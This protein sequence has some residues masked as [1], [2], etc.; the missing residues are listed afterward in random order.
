[1]AGFHGVMMYLCHETISSVFQDIQQSI[2]HAVMTDGCLSLL[3]E[4]IL[5]RQM[6]S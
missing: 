2:H 6:S 1:M 5:D 3:K 4:I